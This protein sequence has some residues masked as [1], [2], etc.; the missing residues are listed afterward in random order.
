MIEPDHPS[1]SVQKQCEVLGLARSSY[2]YEPVVRTDPFDLEVMN[3][4]DAQYTKTPFYG[5]RRMTEVLRQQGLNVNRKRI[6]RVMR[7]MGLEAIYQ[8]PN[9]SRAHPEHV[10]YPY[11]L[12]GLTIERP[13]HVWSMDITYIKM[14]DGFLYLVAVLDWYSRYILAWELSNCLD[15]SFCIAAFERAL[16]VGIPD[17][18]NTDQGVQFT[19]RDFVA[20]VLGSGAKLSMDGRGRA[21]GNIFV[22]R[23]WRTVKYE[24]VYIKDYRNVPEAT[25][26]L[27][28]YLRFYNE[29][30]LHQSLD[31]KT[32][33]QVHFVEVNGQ[34]VR[35]VSPGHP[36]AVLETQ[37][38]SEEDRQQENVQP[39]LS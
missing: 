24:E 16:A 26:S 28:D 9:L 15:T 25:R 33:K 19:S 14:L 17:I 1:L 39:S 20:H 36:E 2:Y 27:S 13:N 21:F 30:R 12:R 4:I 31:Y 32:P 11:L 8:K 10:K 22:E 37:S 7:E 23:L 5:S 35:F 6:V 18:L 29:E 34:S 38:P 3:R